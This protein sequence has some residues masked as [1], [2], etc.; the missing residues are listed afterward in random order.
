M[1]FRLGGR[2][3][4]GDR[5]ISQK[6]IMATKFANKKDLKSLKSYLRKIEKDILICKQ[7]GF[8]LKKLIDARSDYISEI[9][10]KEPDFKP[11]FKVSVK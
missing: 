5:L 2:W 6:V 3:S 8:N 11:L 1:C 10:K 7:N 4:L 9:K